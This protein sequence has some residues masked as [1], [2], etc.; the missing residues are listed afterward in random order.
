MQD[1]VAYVVN[2]N[3]TLIINNFKKAFDRFGQVTYPTEGASF[4]ALLFHGVS[5]FIQNKWIPKDSFMNDYVIP[6]QKTMQTVKSYI[7]TNKTWTDD[8]H[9]NWISKISL[10]CY[11]FAL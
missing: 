2:Y 1:W 10:N 11:L 3:K 8:V 5:S 9:Q 6:L 4:L 7:G